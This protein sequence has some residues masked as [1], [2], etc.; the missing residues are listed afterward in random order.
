MNDDQ[1]FYQALE[2][3]GQSI[4]EPLPVTLSPELIGLLSEQLYRS[5]S[6]AIEELVINGFD[7]EADEA[8]V[9]VPKPESEE[10][11]IVVFDD[12]IGMTYEGIA[13]LWKVGRPKARDE[14]L[15][16]RK[17]RRQIG[18][19]GIGKLST[20][21]IANRVTYVTSTSGQ[22]L[23]VTI[24]YR[25]FVTTPDSTATAVELEVRQFNSVDQ[26]SGNPV[27]RT[28]IERLGLTVEALADSSSWTIVILE[29]LKDKA[30]RMG[31]GRLRWVLRTAMPLSP[32]FRLFLNGEPITS[33]LEDL[34]VVVEFNVA[35]L[36]EARLNTLTTRTG[37]NWHVED[38]RLTSNSFPLGISGTVLVTRETL[39]R[40]S[41]EVMRSEGFFVYVRGRLVNEEDARFGLHEL[42]HATLNRFRATI[43]ADDLDQVIKANRESMEDVKLYHDAQVVLNEVFNEA[44][45]RYTRFEQS[46]QE[47]GTRSREDKRN[48]VPE[49]LVEYP[50]ADA[51]TDYSHNSSGSEPDDSWMYLNVGPDT[52]LDE[53]A[54]SLY[55]T[56]DRDRRYTYQYSDLRDS[57]RL[58]QFDPGLATFRIN[59]NHD[60]ALAYAS[61]PAAERLLH[62]FVTGEALLEVYLRE[63]QVQPHLI[64][65]VLEKRDRLF[66][67]LANAQ[68]FSLSALGRFIRD[69]AN[70]S[71]DLEVAV[72]AGARALGFVAM[73]LGGSGEPD[74]V[75]RFVDYPAGEQKIILEAKSSESSPPAKDIDFAAIR[76][77]MTRHNADGC[78]LLA[79][80]YQGGADANTAMSAKELGISCWTVE[81]L[82][83][84]IEAVEARQISA[85]QI[86]EIVRTRFTP[87]DVGESVASLLAEPTWEPRALYISVVAALR[88]IDHI[89][90]Q[91]PRNISMIAT[92][93]ARADA[94]RDVEE[95]DV[96]GAIRDLAA[97][98][99]GALLLRANDDV[100]VLN[101]DY[102]ELER[103]VQVLT[104]TPGSP[105]RKGAFGEKVPE[106]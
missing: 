19:F 55:S 29:D 57:D 64:G 50:T 16:T 87:Q 82:A 56:L 101:V 86:L 75:A 14:T 99:R 15:H 66:R 24:D 91:S 11:F 89:L 9:F 40:K 92:E 95:A 12:G 105:R 8:R 65:E 38:N 10:R 98:S 106:K 31:V 88:N 7:A 23:G 30:L 42:S 4:S 41:A 32:A 51:L 79:P 5:P 28:A 77:H 102:D 54:R 62:D 18:K 70:R 103:R 83:E 100:I 52:D 97:A 53:L 17:N 44:R 49:P 76:T 3:L 81:R 22:L 34:T 68:M 13:D 46:H 67:G 35:D 58:V 59:S 27:M 73:H 2:S 104:G 43:A 96:R 61:D 94:F 60:M 25:D 33:A 63:A 93:I 85:R 20:Y 39:V 90:T 45:I 26:L 48:W 1:A 69:S 74:G 84:V 21:A 71:Q 80:S 37:E 78:L 47:Q 6:K 72:V 36:P